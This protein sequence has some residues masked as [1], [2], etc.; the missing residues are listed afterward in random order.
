MESILRKLFAAPTTW[1]FNLTTGVFIWAA[2]LGSSW[3]LQ[4]LGHVSVDLIR[5]LLD[6]H[7]KSKKR[8]PRRSLAIFGNL[9]SFGVISAILRGG[10]ILCQRDIKLN[11]LAPYNFRFPLIISHSAIVV[12]SGLMLLTLLFILIDLIFGGEKYM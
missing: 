5:N 8:W 3:A 11:A 2:F 9:L 7:T 1:S 6:K 12:G 10:W 4:E